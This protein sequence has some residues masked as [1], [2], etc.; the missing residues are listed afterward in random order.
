MVFFLKSLDNSYLI[1]I[2]Y[3]VE[4]NCDT[5]LPRLSKEVSNGHNSQAIQFD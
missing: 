4:L 1:G 5:S 3:K 2:T